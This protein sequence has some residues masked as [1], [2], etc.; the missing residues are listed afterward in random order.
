MYFKLNKLIV[1]ALF[2]GI[3]VVFSQ[4]IFPVN[5]IPISLTSLAVMICG[6]VLGWKMGFL[7]LF[8][9]ILMGTIGL[10]VF[11]GFKGGLGVLLGPT[12]GFIIGYL[13]IAV[14]SG[15]AFRKQRSGLITVLMLCFANIICYIIG[16][17]W[18]M[19]I[20]NSGFISAISV[21]V[22]PF[23]MGDALKVAMAYPVIVRIKKRI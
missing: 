22:L 7:T 13:V 8:L 11:A 6:G 23:V 10:P 19:L 2:T 4:I 5:I 21:C 18:Y 17:L 16:T 20:T 1:C 12:G 15:V 3:I 14:L 9:Y